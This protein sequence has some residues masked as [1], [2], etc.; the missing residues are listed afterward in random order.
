MYA[1]EWPLSCV[2]VCVCV[3]VKSPFRAARLRTVNPRTQIK[4]ALTPQLALSLVRFVRWIYDIFRTL[5]R[6]P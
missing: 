6:Y 2:G 1:I 4:R 3:C 5:L